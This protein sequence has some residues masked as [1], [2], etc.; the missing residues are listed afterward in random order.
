MLRAHGCGC[1]SPRLCTAGGYDLRPRCW[2]RHMIL[3][4]CKVGTAPTL[5][6]RPASGHER[7]RVPARSLACIEAP[8]H[9]LFIWAFLAGS[10]IVAAS[11]EPRRERMK[12]GGCAPRL[13]QLD[14]P[15]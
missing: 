7:S 3:P 11:S 5:E 9:T 14:N 2:T 13:E 10:G 12:A 6:S 4:T 8:S 1:H 15:I